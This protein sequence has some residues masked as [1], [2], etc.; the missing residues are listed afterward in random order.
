VGRWLALGAEVLGGLDQ[1][2]AE[3]LLPEA[4][5][6]HAR[7]QRVLGVGQPLR[8]PQAV[9]RRTLGQW[10]QETRRAALDPVSL[11]IVLAALEQIRGP[12]IGFSLKTSVVGV[13]F[14]IASFSAASFVISC[15][16]EKQQHGCRHSH[17]RGSARAAASCAPASA[18]HAAA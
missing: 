14:S 15:C 6:G 3:E 4:V 8:E 1:A 9:F 17:S 10:R 2:R 12:D 18:W 13:V 7:G 5:D 11:A 16:K